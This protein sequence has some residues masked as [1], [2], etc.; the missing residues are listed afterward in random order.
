MAVSFENIHRIDHQIPANAVD[1][2]VIWSPVKSLFLLSMYAATVLGTIYFLRVDTLILFILKT[3]TVLLFGHSLGMHRRLIPKSFECPKW[4]EKICVYLGTMVGLGGPLTLIKTHDFRDWAQ[5][6]G[7]CHDYFAHRQPALKDAFWQMHC[8]LKLDTPPRFKIED[9]IANDTFYQ[10]I[11][12]HWISVHLPWVIG[13]YLIGGWAWVIWGVCAQI[14]V[15]TTGHWLIGYMA[16]TDEAHDWHVDGA[17]VQGRNV[18]FAGLMTMGE[19]WHNNHHA[20][21]GSAK[22]GLLPGQYDPGFWML[23]LLEHLGLVWGIKLPRDLPQRSQL[24]W[25]GGPYETHSTLY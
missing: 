19:A 13:F 14:A 16:H 21:P 15:T 1:G 10:L 20:F 25:K 4:L 17:G 11:N 22:I 23:K 5:R 7:R 2:N 24:H 12:R 8:D 6:Q 3:I 18:K 9:D